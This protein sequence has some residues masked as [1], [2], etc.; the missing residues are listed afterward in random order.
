MLLVR[1]GNLSLSSGSTK[2]CDL[3]SHC[4][5][6]MQ[7]ICLSIFMI[8]KKNNMIP[9]LKVSKTKVLLCHLEGLEV[10]D[11][12]MNSEGYTDHIDH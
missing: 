4:H 8:I 2:V 5:W 9:I 3:Q 6:S 1:I 12:V 11:V 10:G 7:L